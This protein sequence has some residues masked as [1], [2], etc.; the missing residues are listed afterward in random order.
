MGSIRYLDARGEILLD[1][2]LSASDTVMEVAV[3]EGVPGIIAECGGSMSCATCHVYVLPESCDGFEAKEDMEEELLDGLEN[4][5]EC[6]RLSCQLIPVAGNE[7]LVVTVP[8]P[9]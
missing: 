2:T 1:A 5:T 6:S 7:E 9:V 8:D 4:R 3:R